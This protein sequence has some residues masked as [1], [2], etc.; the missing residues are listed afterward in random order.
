MEDEILVPIYLITGFL[1]S[2]KTQFL[3]FTI[4]QDY[5]A[6]PEKTLLIVCEEGEEEYQPRELKKYNTEVVVI[7]KEEDLTPQRL[8]ALQITCNPARV[9]IEYNG[10]WSVKRL[11]EMEMPGG[12]GIV[13]RITIVDGSTFQM[14]MNSMKS[15]FMEMIRKADLVMFNRCNVEDPL[16][17]YRRSIKAVNQ[18]AEV[19]FEDEEGE[20]DV[21][22]DSMPFDVDAPVIEI[23]PEDY[24]IWYIDAQDNPAR[25]HKKMV[26]F[27]AK[28]LKPEELDANT[29]V[30]GRMAMTCCAE[31]MTFIGYVCIYDDTPSLKENDWVDVTAKISMERHPA[32]DD[33]GPV[34]YAD[35]V[36]VCEPLE[37]ELVYFN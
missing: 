14:Y 33:Y 26:H 22:A 15:L 34:L 9:L 5:F 1:E 23:A 17:S 21:F 10:M 6:I 28:V 29:F 3:N 8:L 32:Y 4:R 12:W 18:S 25:Y 31:D 24:G 20:I 37:E 19:V 11:E 16:P 36:K 13:Q 7:E 35:Q 27:K 2:G 30:P